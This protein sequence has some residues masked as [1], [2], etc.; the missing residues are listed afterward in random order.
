MKAWIFAQCTQ[1]YVSVVGVFLCG[2]FAKGCEIHAFTQKP[3]SVGVDGCRYVN[4]ANWRWVNPL[5]L[6]Y[7][8]MTLSDL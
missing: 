5:S 2:H 6:K 1:K 7:G 8:D 3:F 4:S